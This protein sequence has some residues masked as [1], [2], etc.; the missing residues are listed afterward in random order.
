MDLDFGAS[1]WQSQETSFLIN[2]GLSEKQKKLY[3]DM[4][5]R[6]EILPRHIVLASSGSTSGGQKLVALPK[7][8]FLVSAKAVN[9]H[10]QV[11]KTD[12]WLVPLPW[13]HVGG[14][15]IYARA[16]LSL[17]AFEDI[18]NKR[19]DPQSFIEQLKK[20]KATLTSLVPAQV[21]DL[22]KQ[23]L[24]CPQ[25][26]RAILVGGGSLSEDLYYN[27]RKLGYPVLPTYGMTELASQVATASLSSLNNDRYP[28]LVR[29]PHVQWKPSS[30]GKYQIKSQALFS[31]Y[32]KKNTAGDIYIEDPK[33][34]GWFLVEDR[35]EISQDHIR[36]LG[37]DSDFIRIGG[38]TVFLNDL[39]QSFASL[40]LQ[41]G[42][43]PDSYL[44]IDKKDERLG[45]VIVLV[46]DQNL[47]S[48]G[49]FKI[50]KLLKSE[51]APFEI[52][53][54]FFFLDKI[55][56]SDLGKVL[57]AEIKKLLSL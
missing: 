35:A 3:S 47:S 56:R 22:V 52:P 32:I 20:S 6:V 41:E 4:C 12:K 29:L 36:V 31:F 50:Q 40:L 10:L 49:F 37:R 14:L 23:K 19:W 15:S 53:R 54:E 5:S 51:R 57:W 55:P 39:N 17:C 9:D 43:N 16:Y 30:D 34:E 42:Y 45:A 26:L 13:F 7:E 1:F 2:P 8:A 24:P 28:P 33:K 25:S 48:E 46:S 18:S 27:A 21:H 38:E 44:L 11:Q